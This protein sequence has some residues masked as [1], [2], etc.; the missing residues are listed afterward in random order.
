MLPFKNI[1]SLKCVNG[2]KLCLVKKFMSKLKIL[3]EK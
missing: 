1:S 2:W 3:N